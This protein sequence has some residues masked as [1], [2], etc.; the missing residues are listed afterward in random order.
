LYVVYSPQVVVVVGFFLPPHFTRHIRVQE[1]IPRLNV[2]ARTCLEH[3]SFLCNVEEITGEF[4]KNPFK[5]G[6]RTF[7]SAKYMP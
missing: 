2:P 1:K 3:L 5:N 4:I 6:G 7:L